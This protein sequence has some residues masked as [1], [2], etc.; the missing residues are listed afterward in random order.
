MG[1]NRQSKVQQ[2]QQQVQLGNNKTIL[3]NIIM[4]IVLIHLDGAP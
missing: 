3:Q 4:R 2:E 1:F